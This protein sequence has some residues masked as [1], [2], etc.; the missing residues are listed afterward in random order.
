MWLAVDH[1]EQI[2]IRRWRRGL[3]GKV[4]LRLAQDR[5]FPI[6]HPSTIV[7]LGLLVQAQRELRPRALLDVG[8]GS[9][10]LAL[11]G[12][13]LG[14][15]WVVGCDLAPQ[16]LRVCREN[17]RRNGLDPCCN[18]FQGSTE[19]VRSPL[20]LVVANLPFAVQLA[21]QEEFLRLLAHP[22]G[23]I[24]AGF[25]D[26]QEEQLTD[27][28]LRQRLRLVRRLTRDFWEPDPLESSY[29]WVGLY[30]QQD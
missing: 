25:R 3:W 28:Y 9:G 26:L 10:V 6:R 27:Y 18:W 16:T 22:G 2:K 5:T 30:F 21:K 23:L 20:P 17:A 29:T 14:I 19:A 13:A 8:C 4:V 15:P 1:Q 12:A 24:L 7:S 11:T